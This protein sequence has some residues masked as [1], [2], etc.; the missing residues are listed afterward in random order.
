MFKSV[1]SDVV[2]HLN[3]SKIFSFWKRYKFN[4]SYQNG[5]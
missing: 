4:K 1:A 5:F 2:N 3:D